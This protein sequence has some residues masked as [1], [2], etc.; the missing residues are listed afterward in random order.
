MAP[1]QTALTEIGYLIPTPIQRQTIPLLLKGGDLLGIAQTGTGK[2]AA[3]ALPILDGLSRHRIKPLPRR[4][5][6]LILTPTRELASQI[7]D[8]F[9]KYGRHLRLTRVVVYGGVGQQPQVRALARGVDIL[10]ATPGR[11]LDL[12]NQGHVFLDKLEVFVLDEADRM[13]DMGFIIDIRRLMA[14]LPEKRQTLLFSATMPK[15][16]A[17]LADGLLR[18]PV[19][20]EVTPP[21]TTVE[22]ID[23][24]IMFVEKGNKRH[25][26]HS[27][28]LQAD[29]SRALVFTRTKHGADKVTR[30]LAIQAV[31]SVAIHGD[32]SQGMREKALSDFR[33]GR[34]R[35][36]V[37]TDIAA[38]GI[39]VVGISHVINF[40][41]P[42][43]PESYVHR[44]G[45]TA[46]AHADGA[47][48]SFCDADERSYL[49]EIERLTRQPIPVDREHDY[50]S[51][52]AENAL[53][54]P[55]TKSRGG[56]KPG[57]SFSPQ[58]QRS[59]RVQGGG[60]TS[61]SAVAAE[62]AIPAKRRARPVGQSQG[63]TTATGRRPR[64]EN[65]GGARPARF[66]VKRG[67]AKTVG[68]ALPSVA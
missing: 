67:P 25:L 17:A 13:L 37:A 42:N 66:A 44:I 6:V 22:R 24:K 62:P 21:A 58:S 49:R 23:Q 61:G 8:S 34:V 41:L 3:F 50:H 10:V 18:D 40:D 52:E 55:K 28:L 11:L 53:Q 1:I 63:T 54:G 32:K 7:N 60:R 31:H 29:V 56:N 12:I 64:V 68:L 59:T 47:A 4:A 16:I 30:D 26:L 45:R 57:R 35:V 19:R 2:T 65:S 51:P 5:R 9:G 27:I 39:D 43:E 46:R 38:R 33:A 20:V 36:L 15:E 48:I 14:L